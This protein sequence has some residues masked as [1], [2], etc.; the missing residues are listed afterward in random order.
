[1][2]NHNICPFCEKKR[3][4]LGISKICNFLYDNNI[5]FKLEHTFEHCKNQKKLPFDVYIPKYNTIIEY[6]GHHHFMPV[7]FG[8]CSFEKAV[9][10]FI[11]I[12]KNDCIK[13]DFCEKNN[14]KIIRIS[15]L[16]KNNIIQI[17]NKNI[18]T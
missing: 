18:I 1:M 16:H 4:S 13:N 9:E 17:L 10:N 15:Y 12:Q 14:I 2:K 6:D 3:I 11:K 7:Q 5:D 8:G